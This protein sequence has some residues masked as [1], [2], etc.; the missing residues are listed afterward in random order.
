MTNLLD[1]DALI[2]QATQDGVAQLVVGAVVLR[3]GEVPTV[4][5][6][7]RVATDFMGG[8]EELP[9]GKVEEGESLREALARELLE[10]TGLTVRHVRL[11]AF[12]FD[13]RS[14]SGRLSRQ[15]N[16]VVS[17]EPGDVTTDPCEHV[18]FRWVP[19]ALL[20]ESRLTP[21]IIQALAELPV[22]VLTTS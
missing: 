12:A 22:A 18:G 6:L 9:S 15:F 5:V 8:I 16:F 10:E 17:V 2:A 1:D 4:L 3:T 7:D 21:N 20:A 11:Y 13:Y 14:G 19:L